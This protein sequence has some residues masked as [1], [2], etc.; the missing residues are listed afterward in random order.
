M[1]PVLEDVGLAARISEGNTTIQSLLLYSS[2]CG[3]GLDCVPIPGDANLKDLALIYLDVAAMA[4]KLN[5]PLTARLFPAPGLKAGEVTS[6]DSPHLT[7][8]KV[9]P[10][11]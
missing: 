7:N 5:K 3:C 1:L 4:F 8:C 11:L 10:L 6:F 9:I 2:V